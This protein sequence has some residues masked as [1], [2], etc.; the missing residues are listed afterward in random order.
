MGVYPYS[1][2]NL[3]HFKTHALFYFNCQT[4][5]VKI[6]K[7]NCEKLAHT[8]KINNVFLC[9]T[10]TILEQNKTKLAGNY[11]AV[12]GQPKQHLILK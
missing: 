5:E 9:K 12:K 8:H 2:M 7:K 3:V 1:D 6:K 10:I 4:Q 11:S